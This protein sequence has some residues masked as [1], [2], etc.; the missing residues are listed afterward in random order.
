MYVGAYILNLN[1]SSVF[2]SMR[3]HNPFGVT[4]SV[5]DRQIIDT[6]PTRARRTAAL[7]LGKGDK[8]MQRSG[9][10]YRGKARWAI[11]FGGMIFGLAYV[12]ATQEP[13]FDPWADY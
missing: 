1:G 3:D 4:R 7:P 11:L 2:P 5:R 12:F 13:E 10:R 8:F 6:V 9:N